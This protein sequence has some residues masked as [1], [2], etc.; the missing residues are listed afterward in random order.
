MA[1]ISTGTSLSM[2]FFMRKF[3]DGDT[4]AYKSATRSS[5]SQNNLSYKDS[6]ALHKAAKKLSSYKFNTDENESS[7]R[8]TVLAYVNTYNNALSS[9]S[10]S[11][12][13]EVS[14]FS[15]QF[16]SLSN[17]YSD[18][19]Q[20]VGISVNKDGSL[21]VSETL[22]EKTSNE[23]LQKVFGKDSEFLRS[24]KSL[25]RRMSNNSS[26][27]LY[28]EITGAGGTIDLTL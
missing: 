23:K 21:K 11:K 10:S 26:E 24:V 17:K 5:Y 8:S 4:K 28:T 19:L 25:S 12:S 22:L 20:E 15:K 14:R 9:S 6:Q 27:L 18:A 2:T 13:H 16:K 1:T 3:Y 7:V